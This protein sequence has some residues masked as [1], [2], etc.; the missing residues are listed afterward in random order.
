MFASEKSGTTTGDRSRLVALAESVSR[1][2]QTANPLDALGHIA[3]QVAGI[4]RAGCIIYL[5]V[6]NKR[7]LQVVAAHHSDPKAL[8]LM[9]QRLDGRT[10][11]ADQGLFQKVLTSPEPVVIPGGLPAPAGSGSS[12]SGDPS[13]GLF[14]GRAC[15]MVAMRARGGSLGALG[16]VDSSH[17]LGPE[18][19]NFLQLIA[20]IGGLA[21]GRT[22]LFSVLQE[23][24]SRAP[25]PQELG[26]DHD[27]QLRLLFE[28]IPAGYGIADPRTRRLVLVNRRLA[29]ML[30]YSVE[31]ALSLNLD[32]FHPES[33]V[34]RVTEDFERVVSG[35]CLLAEDVPVLRK[36][37][38]KIHVSISAAPI[39]IGGQTYIGGFWQNVTERKM[40]Q[41]GL[42]R[43]EQIFAAFMDHFPGLAC[44]KDAAGRYIFA[45]PNCEKARCEGSHA[46][47]CLEK[48]D[49]EF[50]E[51]A[52]RAEEGAWAKAE[53]SQ[54]IQVVRGES[55]PRAWMVSRF[56]VA[57]DDSNTP[58]LGSIGLDVTDRY[59]AMRKLDEASAQLRQL[60]SYLIQTRESERRDMAIAL[61]GQLGQI[62][63]LLSVNL[64]RSSRNM[65]E[66]LLGYLRQAQDLA[67]QALSMTR[68]LSLELRPTMLDDLGLIPALEWYRGW[69]TNRTGVQ[70][71]LEQTDVAGRRFGIDIET[72]AYRIVQEALTNVARHARVNQA[73][74]RLRHDSDS[75]FIQIE[76]HGCGFSLSEASSRWSSLGLLDMRSRASMLGGRLQIE[77]QVHSGCR[78]T[79][80]LPIRS[81]AGPT[82]P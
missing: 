55:G 68:N 27:H 80:E 71:E 63:S 82:Q 9:R 50:L 21:I 76:D 49:R 14:A 47:E 41:M 10:F 5:P 79:V 78:I 13:G 52:A 45:N 54:T 2:A 53:E 70:V 46:Q 37:G 8:E 40:A 32:R 6:G 62:L 44:I 1:V 74:L 72:G 3:E 24:S 57:I 64:D 26:G 33:V 19:L 12:S 73:L 60:T 81:A 36:D 61:H 42:K 77:T 17:Y 39:R 38:A 75:L 35:E 65:P 7:D 67:E 22:N 18:E 15:T 29:E 56:L 25:E 43:N 31:E 16:L 58:L 34:P 20:N 11:P 4:F 48:G 30:G 66:N 28:T 51:K 59:E 23:I 69:F